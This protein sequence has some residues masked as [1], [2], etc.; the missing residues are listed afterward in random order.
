MTAMTIHS[1]HSIPVVTEMDQNDAERETTPAGR[2]DSKHSKVSP[3]PSITVSVAP[4]KPSSVCNLLANDQ[5]EDGAAAGSMRKSASS[6]ALVFREDRQ[7]KNSPTESKRTRQK[8]QLKPNLKSSTKLREK[9]LMF[10]T[11][12]GGASQNS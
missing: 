11:S 9:K 5:S 4:S 7:G 12:G 10:K 6:G 2:D 3:I 1:M 8:F